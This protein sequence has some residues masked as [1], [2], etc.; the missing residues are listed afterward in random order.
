M[1]WGHFRNKWLTSLFNVNINES[2]PR[3][4]QQNLMFSDANTDWDYTVPSQPDSTFG[5]ADMEDASLANFFSRPIKIASFTDTPGS[6]IFQ[7]FDPWSLYFDNPRVVNRVCNFNLLRAKLCVKFLINGN[8]FYFGRYIASYTPLPLVDQFT[9]NRVTVL[10]DIVEASQRPHIYIDPCTSQGGTLCLPFV[11][12]YNALIIPDS[13]WSLMGSINL[14]SMTNLQHANAATTPLTIS[15]FAWAED[16]E[17]SIPTSAEPITLVPQSASEYQAGPLSTPAGVVARVAAH[18]TQIPSIAPY[19]MATQMVASTVAAVAKM[20]GFSRPVVVSEIQ[21]FRPTFGNYANTNIPDNCHKLTLD[22]KQEVTVDSRV[23]GL[24]GHDEMTIKAIATRESYLTNFTWD[25]ATPAESLLFSGRVT[26]ALWNAVAGTNTEYHLTPMA[27][28]VLPFKWW[29][30]SINYRFQVMSSGF[31]K[32]R[33]KVVYDPRYTTGTEYNVNYV[34]I[35]DISTEKDFT[36]TAGWGSD[37]PFLGHRNPGDTYAP[38]ATNGTPLP[39]GDIL[40]NNGV[41]SVYVVNELTV[42]NS[43]AVQLLQVNVFVSA[44]DDFEVVEPQECAVRN[45]SWVTPPAPGFAAI[46]EDEESET[47]TRFDLE[48]QSAEGDVSVPEDSRP[49]LEEDQLMATKVHGTDQIYSVMFGDPIGSVRQVVKR[50][51]LFTSYYLPPVTVLVTSWARWYLPDF[52]YY[53]GTFTA[54]AVNSGGTKNFCNMTLLNWFTPAYVC[55]RGGTRWKFVKYAGIDSGLSSSMFHVKR[56]PCTTAY[57]ATQ[58]TIAVTSQELMQ[59]NSQNQPGAIDGAQTQPAIVNPVLEIE[60]PYYTNRRFWYGK[61][62]DMTTTNAAT[63]FHS[64]SCGN[65]VT[66]GQMASSYSAAADDFSLSFF[67]GAP[68]LYNVGV[69][70]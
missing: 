47:P 23:A 24:A 27:F 49:M 18:L 34:R 31:H 32:G 54:G 59:Q 57:S 12:P 17:L 15:V 56:Q 6:A 70:T 65:G 39:G 36:I 11:W 35:V 58:T 22:V 68:I 41:I 69:L 46:D 37:K 40:F 67:T 61:Y 4:Q 10:A 9:Q 21:S 51:S 26:P 43:A 48:P 30:G 64:F 5:T 50:Y 3:L 20:F 53:R 60:L 63:N 38:F 45:Y 44:S 42:P 66:F 28:A 25:A 1:S 19:A 8:S 2:A 52:P 29:R 14:R 33:L 55:R 62:R 16:V 13:E 7:N